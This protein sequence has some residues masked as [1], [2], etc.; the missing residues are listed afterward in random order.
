MAWDKLIFPGTKTRVRLGRLACA[1]AAAWFL[2]CIAFYVGRTYCLDLELFGQI[3]LC[4]GRFFAWQAG[5]FFGLAILA[6]IFRP[7]AVA[8][9]LGVCLI[10]STAWLLAMP[11]DAVFLV[12]FALVLIWMICAV[13]GVRR[14]IA[15]AAGPRYATWG[16]A[17]AATYAALVP[18]CFFLGLFR[19][20]TPGIVGPLALATALPGALMDWRRLPVLSRD[21]A[22]RFSRLQFFDLCL[23]EVIWV[24]LALT[25]VGASTSELRSDAVRVHLPYIHQVVQDQGISHQYACWHRL[26]PMGMQ[27]CCAAV[28][29]LG[30]DAAAKWFSWLVLP[31]L[32]LLV[33]EEVRRRSGSGRLGLFAAAAVLGC[34]ILVELATSIYVVHLMTLLCTAGF[35]VLFRALRPPCPR[36]ILLSAIIMASMAQVKYTGL[37]FCVVWGLV[38]CIGLLWQCRWRVA[39]LWSIAGGAF[40]AAVASPWYVHVYAGTGNPF[41][42]YLHNW[43]PSPY[44]VDGFT[45][46]QVFEKS[47]KLDPGIGGVFRFPWNATFDTHRFA[48]RSDGYLGFW[49]LALAP[50]LLL[51]R[52][53]KAGLYWGMALAGVAMIAGIVSYTPYIRYWLPAYSLLLTACVLA[54][55]ALIR[56]IPWRPQ[57][58]FWPPLTGIAL[59]GLLLLPSPLLFVSLPWEEYAGHISTEERLTRRF[60][61]YPAVKQLNR[62]LSP[63]EGVISTLFDG[64]H[65]IGGRS[66][67][68]RFWW[69]KLHGIHSVE[70]FTDFCQRHGIRYWIV[71]RFALPKLHDYIAADAIAAEYWIDERLVTAW[72][73]VAIYDVSEKP[74]HLWKKTRRYDWPAVLEKS[75]KRWAVSN[76]SINWINLKRDSAVRQTDGGILLT[77][78]G[79]VIHR[80]QP[81]FE[82]GLCKVELD[83]RSDEF[84][85]PLL[86]IVWYDAN[87]EILSRTLGDAHKES[88]HVVWLYSSVPPGAEVGWVSFWEWKGAPIQL[89]RGTVIFWPPL[90]PPGRDCKTH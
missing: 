76:A 23:L 75:E 2:F 36:G 35:V 5:G 49:V 65:L 57:K 59:A 64:V 73:T 19:V 48:E 52:P 78:R 46:Q 74:T 88:D 39:V 77:G 58:A 68:F 27:T 33:G 16:V 41:Y 40:L 83:V 6:G 60:Y 86:E 51:A 9:A 29:A 22:R 61:G 62:I 87:G 70:L 8:G 80:L 67:E 50:C 7:T 20:I 82:N 4:A 71:N 47:F 18:I 79:R 54:A 12:K 84:T 37:V 85:Y 42:P 32:T 31:A 25:F 26:Q 1:L 3:N 10:L 63:D 45:L 55:G 30:A 89:K 21:F 13:N 34:P 53:R 14:L 44:W 28:A 90:I 17:A 56:S 24:I 72:G 38:L 11:C 66:F 69:N 43:F 81:E 15:R